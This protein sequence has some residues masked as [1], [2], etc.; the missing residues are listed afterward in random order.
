MRSEQKYNF[1]DDFSN[2]FYLMEMFEFSIKI[3]LNFV[4]N[5][6]V[7]DKSALGRVMAWHLFGSKP[8]PEPMMT[9]LTNTYISLQA[10]MS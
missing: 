1:T 6:V 4:S 8:L 3:P 9:Q 7:Y 5:G 2:A 10:S